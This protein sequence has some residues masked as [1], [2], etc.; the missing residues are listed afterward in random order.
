[1][2]FLGCKMDKIRGK[3]EVERLGEM[4]KM[5][6]SMAWEWEGVDSVEGSQPDLWWGGFSGF[7][8]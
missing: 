5:K 2:K 3:V 7:E 1:M 4:N 8:K 6:L